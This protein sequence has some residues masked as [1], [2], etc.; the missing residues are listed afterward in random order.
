MGQRLKS[1]KLFLLITN[2]RS[3]KSCRLL[4]A[5]CL[6]SL[7]A[8]PSVSNAMGLRVDQAPP[9]CGVALPAPGEPPLAAAQRLAG[10]KVA[11][12]QSNIA[13]AWLGSPT[14]RY[15]HTALGSRYHAGSLHVLLARSAGNTG[16]PVEVAYH[17]PLTR[18]F[19]D[20]LVRLVD[21]DQD[22]RDEVIV[23]EADALRGASVL[24][25]GL[26]GTGDAQTLV[27]LARSPPAGS[28]FRWLN[29]VGIADFDG[30]GKLD[31]AAVITPH[32]GGELTLYHYAPPK[33][34][35]YAKAFDTSNHL[36]GATEQQLSVVLQKP[37]QRP[38]VIVP[39]MSLKA[40]HALRW[41]GTAASG[42]FKELADVVALP[43]R[44][45]RI[46]RLPD[47]PGAV[48]LLLADATWRR[49]A[50]LH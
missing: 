16:P 50:L 34:V 48:C 28:T 46:T 49:V 26:V 17:L 9:N 37:G 22:G 10:S 42:K 4:A 13:W 12:G 1:M 44:I 27:E 29:P 19:E 40:L 39:D 2:T 20:L 8:L 25:L 11:Q 14:A 38:T 32:I 7:A 3:S 30:D 43:A 36:M 23:V 35:P 15:P 41:E 5:A 18:V 31:V 6:I 33:L 24:V 47:A 21:L 45:E